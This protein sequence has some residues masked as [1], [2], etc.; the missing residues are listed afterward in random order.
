M[1]GRRTLWEVFH[2]LLGVAAAYVIADLCAW[3]YP[4]AESD[5]WIV[6]IVAMVVT[7]AMGIP[8][9]R[10]AMAEDRA[11]KVGK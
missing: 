9:V 3:S 7:V 6:A 1:I 8:A 11:R 10:R 2:V 5:I 4:L